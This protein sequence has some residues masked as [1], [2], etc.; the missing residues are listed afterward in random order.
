MAENLSKK[1]KERYLQEINI[2]E[3]IID[4]EKKIWD[5]C[6]KYYKGN[7]NENN[8][9]D[10][11]HTN[12]VMS[13]IETDM[14]NYTFN[15]PKWNTEPESTLGMSGD[16]LVEKQIR[17]KLTEEIMNHHA[18]RHGYWK[19]QQL[20]VLDAE[21]SIGYW[22]VFLNIETTDEEVPVMVDNEPKFDE[23]G[24]VLTETDEKVHSQKFSVKR[25]K[26]EYLLVD[27]RTGNFLES[28]QWVA[29][30]KPMK[31]DK[32]RKKFGDGMIQADRT[33]NPMEDDGEGDS[34]NKDL[35]T[36]VEADSE[37]AITDSL[38]QVWVYEVW[39]RENQRFFYIVDEKIYK[40][41]DIPEEY[42][43][44]DSLPYVA[45]KFKDVPNR[46]YPIPNVWPQIPINKT[47]NMAKTALHKYRVQM[48]PKYLANVQAF[49][50]EDEIDKLQSR[51]TG[52]ILRVESNAEGAVVPAPIAELPTEV[53]QEMSTDLRDFRI[54]SGTTRAQMG[55]P[56]PDVTATQS[57][58]SNQVSKTKSGWKK[59][60]VR[61][62]FTEIGMKLQKLIKHRMK[63][64]GVKKIAGPA[65]EYW[66]KYKPDDIKGE[67]NV[68]V[69][70]G[71]VQPMDEGTERA[72]LLEFM[73]VISSNPALLK[74][75]HMP[76]LAEKVVE[77]APGVDRSVL[78]SSQ[79]PKQS[80][81]LTVSD[82][83]KQ[84]KEGGTETG[85]TPPT[86]AEPEQKGRRSN[87][88]Q[89]NQNRNT[90]GRGGG[91]GARQGSAQGQS[92][93]QFLQQAERQAQGGREQGGN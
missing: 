62:A 79:I 74:Q 9:D 48:I 73:Q 53:F 19:H 6:R 23:E 22:K 27:P 43:S 54:V 8:I 26:P 36:L 76:R 71:S 65:G 25:V 90:T 52:E 5:L 40:V 84:L 1:E 32:A 35:Q 81:I 13:S 3:K 92:I 69:E 17:A 44:M 58:F 80:E 86:Q 56:D 21:L 39:D 20:G 82:L 77:I 93:N 4:E 83:V 55:D 72:Q 51:N 88:P 7:Q 85:I 14:P 30:K 50:D 16:E 61:N 11:Q 18:E 29:E 12:F 28:A 89:A 45:L 49:E 63:T 24:N 67:Y 47:Y 87:G 64:G 57:N 38:D 42:R 15:S 41:N 10:F 75:F 33:F 78:L 34:E 91:L 70:F 37:M 60:K 46:W 66:V 31:V 68:S 59:A 2:A